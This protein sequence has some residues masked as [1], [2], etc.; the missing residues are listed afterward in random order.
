M[1]WVIKVTR[2]VKQFRIT[3]PGTFCKIHDINEHDYMVI[4]DKDRDNITIERMNY[5][6]KKEAKGK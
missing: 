3:L 6:N 5:G 4:S 1:R 2:S